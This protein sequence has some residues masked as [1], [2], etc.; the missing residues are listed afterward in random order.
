MLISVLA[1]CV[2]VT[3]SILLSALFGQSLSQFAF[4]EDFSFSIGGAPMPPYPN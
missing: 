4:V 2:I 3:L 1:F